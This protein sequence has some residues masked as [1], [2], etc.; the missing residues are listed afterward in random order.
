MNDASGN[1]DLK[2]LW[3]SFYSDTL[4]LSVAVIVL[5]FSCIVS[6]NIRCVFNVHA[7]HQF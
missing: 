4:V 6:I 3:K 1:C 2:Q 5:L 7:P